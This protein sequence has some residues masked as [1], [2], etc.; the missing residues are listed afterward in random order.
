MSKSITVTLPNDVADTL[1]RHMAKVAE[2]AESGTTTSKSN[3][4]ATA[5]KTQL[6]KDGHTIIETT[7]EPGAPPL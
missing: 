4:V 1:D 3:Y 6:I 2:G 5:I 7:P